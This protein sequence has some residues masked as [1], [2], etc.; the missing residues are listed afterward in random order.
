MSVIEKA[1]NYLSSLAPHIRA[2]EGAKIIADLVEELEITQKAGLL[3]KRLEQ[4]ALKEA[5]QHKKVVE[6]AKEYF[7]FDRGA[8]LDDKKAGHLSE[9]SPATVALLESLA[10]LEE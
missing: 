4:R 9:R 5:E 3:N 10:Q 8:Y 6:A 7:N 1:E 2:R